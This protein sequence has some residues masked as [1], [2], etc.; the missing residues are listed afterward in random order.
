MISGTE[1]LLEKLVASLSESSEIDLKFSPLCGKSFLIIVD[2]AA[3]QFLLVLD[4]DNVR[5]E[6]SSNTVQTTV[7]YW[8]KIR[9]SVLED[10]L[11]GRLDPLVA[12]VT[13]RVTTNIDPMIGPHFR[14][15]LLAGQRRTESDMGWQTAFKMKF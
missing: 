1:S 10:I 7:D 13:R 4:V 9:Q 8:V 12:I 6:K 14:S 2:D 11:C 15:L 3:E 5:F